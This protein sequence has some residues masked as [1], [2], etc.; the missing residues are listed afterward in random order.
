MK[1]DHIVGSKLKT[2]LES[3]EDTTIWSN[4][5]SNTQDEDRDWF[6][7]GDDEE[8]HTS[9]SIEKTISNH[10]NVIRTHSYEIKSLKKFIKSGFQQILSRIDSLEKAR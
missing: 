5:N 3:S 9:P 10:E 7:T 4:S 1:L 8:D 6:I 2:A